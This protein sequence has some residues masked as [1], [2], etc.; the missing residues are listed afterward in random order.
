MAVK[1]SNVFLKHYVQPEVH[2]MA[3]QTLDAEGQVASAI[4]AVP[5][6]DPCYHTGLSI[7]DALE[8]FEQ[9]EGPRNV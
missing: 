5:D 7:I 9:A 2:C 1:C 3:I 4:P 6:A 8:L